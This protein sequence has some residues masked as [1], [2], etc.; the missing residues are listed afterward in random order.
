[1][2]SIYFSCDCGQLLHEGFFDIKL[3][4]YNC[5]FHSSHLKPLM[6]LIVINC[7]FL[8]VISKQAP[9]QE[10]YLDLIL[11]DQP[12]NP[13][14][15]H[16]MV[17]IF[18]TFS[19]SCFKWRLHNWRYLDQEVVYFHGQYVSFILLYSI[20]RPGMILLKKTSESGQK[21]S[22]TSSCVL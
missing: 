2:Y 5:T 9:K 8:I 19:G 11:Q 7:S 3:P 20:C 13:N 18:A 22:K 16:L 14:F 21:Y 6:S 1:M 12:N 17:N 10:R 15:Y 4:Q